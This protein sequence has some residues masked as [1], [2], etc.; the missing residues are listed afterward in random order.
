MCNACKVKLPQTSSLGAS[1]EFKQ[2]K[3]LF[4]ALAFKS[5]SYACCS[6]V[7]RLQQ[8][9]LV[10]ECRV[11]APLL[12]ACRFLTGITGLIQKS[13]GGQGIADLVVK[14]ARTRRMTMLACFGAGCIIFFDSAPP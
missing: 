7:E 11:R 3:A 12:H 9:R 10:E 1:L 2:A 4:D 6:I 13:G 14:H 8:R 5:C